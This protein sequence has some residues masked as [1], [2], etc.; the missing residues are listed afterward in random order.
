MIWHTIAIIILAVAGLA[1]SLYIKKHKHTEKGMVCPMG[2]NCESL[3]N[4]R[5]SRFFGVPVETLGLMYYG[6]VVLFYL[7]TLFRS[8]PD[9]LTLIGLLLTG[10]AFGFTLYL[11]AVQ[12]FVVKKWCTLC[13]A[14]GALSFLIVVIA[15]IKFE[16]LFI[17]F[18]YSSHDLLQWLYLAG[19]LAGTIA[20]TLYARTFISFLRDFSISRNE[21]RRLEMFSHTAWVALAFVVLPGI[22]LVLSDTW[23]EITGGSRFIVILIVVGIIFVY[24]IYANMIVG[25]KLLDIHFGDHPELD[26][27][28][29]ASH[30]KTTLAFITV[31]VTSWYSL[32]LLSVFS[33]F[34]T[35]SAALL[36]LYLAL[37]ILAVLI[38]LRTETIIYHKSVLGRGSEE[39]FDDFENTD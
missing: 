34:G 39:Y 7:A 16:T 30:R 8:V 24:E 21:A 31:G 22:A 28:A 5:F 27:E 9:L 25:R 10:F 12:L 37:S 1:L 29:N 23:R 14:S 13:L 17:D 33:W 35:S 32:L 19:V 36:L 38:A 6:L 26:D 11:T 4:G 20:T 3:V 15:F 2:S 18:V